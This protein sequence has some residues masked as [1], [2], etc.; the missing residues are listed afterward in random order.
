MITVPFYIVESLE[1]QEPRIPLRRPVVSVGNQIVK[2]GSLAK[3]SKLMEQP[4]DCMG[5]GRVRYEGSTMQRAFLCTTSDPSSSILLCTK[6]RF[7]V[8][9]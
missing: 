2:F 3:V 4:R 1:L 9:T 6:R 5:E 8:L 7:G